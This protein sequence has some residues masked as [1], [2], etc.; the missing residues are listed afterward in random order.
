MV[1]SYWKVFS[2]AVLQAEDPPGRELEIH[3]HLFCVEVCR[4]EKE[5]LA[6]PEGVAESLTDALELEWPL[7]TIPKK[8]RRQR[9]CP[10]SSI[11]CQL[12]CGRGFWTRTVPVTK[13][14]HEKDTSD[15]ERQ[16]DCWEDMKTTL[17]RQ[18]LMKPE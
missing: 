18:H 12:P 7:G 11:H 17:W 3:R 4:A 10:S 2:E 14:S 8:A 5:I 16:R 1:L 13:E 15:H 6:L 9:M